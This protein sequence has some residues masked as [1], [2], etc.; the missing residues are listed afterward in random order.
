M[1]LERQRQQEQQKAQ[2]S[3]FQ[4]R[5]R[6]KSASRE[7]TPNRCDEEE[8]STITGSVNINIGS[9]NKGHQ[10]TSTSNPQTLPLHK[11]QTTE[12]KGKGNFRGSNHL[13]VKVLLK[14]VSMVPPMLR[15]ARVL[16]IRIPVF[17][18]L[19]MAKHPKVTLVGAFT[20]I[21]MV[22]TCNLMGDTCWSKVE[23]NI[24]GTSNS[25]IAGTSGYIASSF[26]NGADGGYSGVSN[27]MSMPSTLVMS[28]G[29]NTYGDDIRSNN[30]DST[31]FTSNGD[32]TS[33][34][35]ASFYNQN[36]QTNGM[37]AGAGSPFGGSAAASASAE[38]TPMQNGGSVMSSLYGSSSQNSDT[39]SFLSDLN[40]GGAST[41]H[42]SPSTI[43]SSKTT[44]DGMFDK[45]NHV[46]PAFAYTGN[47]FDDFMSL[48]SSTHSQTG[49]GPDN[50]PGQ[51][52]NKGTTTTYSPPAEKKY[53]DSDARLWMGGSLS[54]G[55][56]SSTDTKESPPLDYYPTEPS[57]F[58]W[59]DPKEASSFAATSPQ[60]SKESLPSSVLNYSKDT[61]VVASND[62]KESTSFYSKYL[63]GFMN[64]KEEPALTNEQPQESSLF[65]VPSHSVYDFPS[66][67]TEPITQKVLPNVVYAENHYAVVDEA[68]VSNGAAK[69]EEDTRESKE[70]KELLA[71]LNTLITTVEQL[72]K[73]RNDNQKAEP[74]SQE[75]VTAGSGSQQVQSNNDELMR[76]PLAFPT[77]T[78]G[79]GLNAENKN[80]IADHPSGE[81]H[82]MTNSAI[83]TKSEDFYAVNNDEIE[84]KL[85]E[86]RNVADVSPVSNEHATLA[87]LQSSEIGTT[88]SSNLPKEA[89]RVENSKKVDAA[90]D[91]RMPSE[92]Q[93]LAYISESH[94]NAT[95]AFPT[96]T[97]AAP[98]PKT[99]KDPAIIPFYW[100]VPLSKLTHHDMKFI[101]L[102]IT[103]VRH[104][105]AHSISLLFFAL[106]T[107]PQAG[108]M[109][110]EKIFASC[111]KFVQASDVEVHYG[112]FHDHVSCAL[113][114]V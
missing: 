43:L 14:V 11:Q 95:R 8:G 54:E 25:N 98:K 21:I 22:S 69:K 9:S 62:P 67:I 75:G 113:S 2:K 4:N 46:H 110:M 87:G 35:F 102:G 44:S 94:H 80:T 51:I 59:K 45:S 13:A 84:E 47:G 12:Y 105:T 36:H 81:L 19:C 109:A 50:I 27:T 17:L 71:K 29:S 48:G 66:S 15:L 78:F 70:K 86:Q 79:A 90:I 55:S 30:M 57:L 61:P 74:T 60:N 52:M 64:K 40:F 42:D 26:G 23:T 49:T 92:L 112:D 20:T 96:T 24:Y 85:Q 33:D 6:I 100:H 58:A 18:I 68:L 101:M 63:S 77:T 97:I 10:T 7:C 91:K 53:D 5:S 111:Y 73:D 88:T 99:T 82:E 32:T 1:E 41:T 31:S 83:P 3:P 104:S 28:P 39:N 16:C 38:S 72:Q 108:G 103:N 37:F 89:P 34:L 106:R 76:P 65:E 107:S 114:F 93:N 56:F